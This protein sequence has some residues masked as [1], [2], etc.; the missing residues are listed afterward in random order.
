MLENVFPKIEKETVIDDN[1]VAMQIGKVYE[2]WGS[3]HLWTSSPS[4]LFFFPFGGGEIILCLHSVT[5]VMAK[6]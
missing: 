5:F 4:N 3:V 2:V 1:S 6:L